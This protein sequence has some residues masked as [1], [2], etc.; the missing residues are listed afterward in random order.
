LA[1]IMGKSPQR[2]FRE[3]ADMDPELHVGRGDVKYHLGHS[4]DYQA[5]N[6][7]SVHLTLCFNPS[8]L[9]WGECGPARTARATRPASTGW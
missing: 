4:T 7:R 1:N 2:I 9:E 6:G 8:H 3:F 5:A